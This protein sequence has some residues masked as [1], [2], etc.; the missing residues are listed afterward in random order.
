MKLICSEFSS[1]A[2]FEYISQWT[3][4]FLEAIIHKDIFPFLLDD[5]Q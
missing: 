2:D 1:D 5:A 4:S 3:V